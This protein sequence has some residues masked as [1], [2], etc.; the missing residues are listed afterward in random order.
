MLDAEFG[1]TPSGMT[2]HAPTKL[3]ARKQKPPESVCF[4]AVFG[5]EF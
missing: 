4:P 5:I 3:R 2:G 1:C